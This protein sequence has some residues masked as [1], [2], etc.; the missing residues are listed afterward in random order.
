MDTGYKTGS[1]GRFRSI[2]GRLGDTASG[3]RT[4]RLRAS[5]W[6]GFAICGPS[7]ITLLIS[8]PS[9]EGLKPSTPS[10]LLS[11]GE[12]WR[13]IA[14]SLRFDQLGNLIAKAVRLPLPAT[15]AQLYYL[16]C[17]LKNLGFDLVRV[18]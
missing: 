17:Q 15:G 4:M 8:S 3:H 9:G 10:E 13:T 14:V 12:A 1:K 18:V 2:S 16:R 5:Y 6:C 11:P 7:W